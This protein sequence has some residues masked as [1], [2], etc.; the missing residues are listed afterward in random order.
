MKFIEISANYFNIV[1]Q[2]ENFLSDSY[3][4]DFLDGEGQS[5]LTVTTND[6]KNAVTFQSKIPEDSQNVLVFYKNHRNQE[7][8]FSD[9]TKER[10]KTADQIGILTLEG[11]I[12]KSIYNSISSIFLPNALNV[13]SLDSQ[14]LK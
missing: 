3:V 5:I 10:P 14:T 13:G 11:G 9:K 7:N 4:K 1:P 2:T 8:R 12:V 6:S